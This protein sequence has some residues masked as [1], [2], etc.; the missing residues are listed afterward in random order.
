M[1]GKEAVILSRSLS[2]CSA[3]AALALLAL[4]ALM[5]CAHAETPRE[6]ALSMLTRGQTRAAI[7]ELEALRDAAPS[8][9]QRWIDL[10]HAY[11]LDHRYDEALGAYDRA[12]SVAPDR[13]E[14]PR[15]GGLRAAS[16]GEWALAKV[17]L[18]EAVRRGDDDP[19]TFHAL[20]LVLL[21]L[22]DRDGAERAYE[23]GLA[24]PM[25]DRDATCVL[26]LAT[27]A[28]AREDAAAA[29]RWYDE[30]ARR[31]PGAP[32]AQF[33]RAWAL[34]T[35]RRWEEAERALDEAA[36]LG[37]GASDVERLR[38][39]LRERRASAS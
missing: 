33:G 21:Q 13:P 10:G 16:W 31:R 18:E 20:G 6:H 25:G 28:V 1:N 24:T 30:L 9:P 5:G 19:A 14:G 22:G 36:S 23:R 2:G 35:L 29:L 26:G 12:A 34:G 39:W 17:R 3:I 4:L 37:G 38:A 15:E 8:D 27:L 11:E 32:G 7:A